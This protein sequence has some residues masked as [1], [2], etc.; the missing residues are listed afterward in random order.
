MCD[1]HRILNKCA[2]D[3]LRNEINRRIS[4]LKQE[5]ITSK[6]DILNREIY[7][8]K[9][10]LGTKENSE[11]KGEAFS[12]AGKIKLSFYFVYSFMNDNSLI[13]KTEMLG[14]LVF[15]FFSLLAYLF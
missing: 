11:Q 3:N 8:I 9:N 14:F 6:L 13:I 1:D 12:I 7:S 15:F 5:E 4:N 10:F 2:I